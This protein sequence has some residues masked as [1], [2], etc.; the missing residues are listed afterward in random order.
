MKIEAGKWEIRIW[1]G[2]PVPLKK[3][4]LVGEW[5]GEATQVL[6]LSVE[7]RLSYSRCS[8]EEKEV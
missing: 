3:S 4:P 6:L 2:L 5:H 1:K 8:S 7:E